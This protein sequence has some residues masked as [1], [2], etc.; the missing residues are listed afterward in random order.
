[1]YSY[2]DFVAR[3]YG[4]PCYS[5]P[6]CLNTSLCSLGGGTTLA[7]LDLASEIQPHDVNAVHLDMVPHALHVHSA[8]ATR[9]CR[10]IVSFPTNNA[11]KLELY[12]IK[13]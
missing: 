12:L 2:G 7:K 1:M 9:V 8:W 6:S 3:F 5:N 13:L 11:I 4:I 10:L